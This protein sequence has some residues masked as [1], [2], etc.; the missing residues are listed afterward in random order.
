[1]N[2]CKHAPGEVK[3]HWVLGV[4]RKQDLKL[5]TASE[6]VFLALATA[7]PTLRTLPYYILWLTEIH[8]PDV[9]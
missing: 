6:L 5:H 8:S 7:H 2:V 3:G 9:E 4:F 1:M